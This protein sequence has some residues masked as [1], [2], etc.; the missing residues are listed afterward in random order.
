MQFHLATAVAVMGFITVVAVYFV[1][2]R[3]I[4]KKEEQKNPS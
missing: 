3:K 4:D 2:V 1:W